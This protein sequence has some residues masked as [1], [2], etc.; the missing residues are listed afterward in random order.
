MPFQVGVQHQVAEVSTDHSWVIFRRL[1]P[2]AAADVGG[3]GGIRTHGKLA[4]SVV[5]KTTALNHSA[6]PPTLK[7]PQT[8]RLSRPGRSTAPPPRR[9]NRLKHL[10]GFYQ[11]AD[12][13]SGP[14]VSQLFPLSAMKRR[15]GHC[16][17]GRHAQFATGRCRCIGPAWPHLP[18][19]QSPGRRGL[20][21]VTYGSSA[22][23]YW[24]ARRLSWLHGG[25][26]LARGLARIATARALRARSSPAG[27]PQVALI[28]GGPGSAGSRKSTSEVG[29]L[30]GR[31]RPALI[32]TDAISLDL[33]ARRQ[34]FHE[35]L[36]CI[37]GQQPLVTAFRTFGRE[38]WRQAHEG[39]SMQ[40]AVRAS[41]GCGSLSLRLTRRSRT[42]SRPRR[43]ATRHACPA[44]RIPP[45]LARALAPHAA[46]RH[47]VA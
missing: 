39:M 35:F 1:H 47:R 12:A 18:M 5:F 36:A 40:R 13:V 31:D 28:Y 23:R 16:S 25:R 29:S 17:G 3:G 4:P 33:C 38:L 44:W 7:E 46:H 34:Q 20:V 19:L 45:P 42:A 8:G 11:A 32:A 41:G 22:H 6:T 26:V 24:C 10:R 27:P 43:A 21:K 30:V 37:S 14:D 15:D 9:S 2:R